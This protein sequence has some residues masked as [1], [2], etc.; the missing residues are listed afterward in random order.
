[1]M[2]FLDETVLITGAKGG[3]GKA[4][5]IK[6][7]QEGANLVLTDIDKEALDEF[8]R[9]EGFDSQRCICVACDVT[10]YKEV[11][12]SVALGVQTFGSIDHLVNCA[13]IDGRMAYIADM[14]EE[15]FDIMMNVNVKGT[16]FFMKYALQDMLKHHKGTIVNIASVAG[17]SASRRKPF[18][19]ASKHAVNGLSKSA[20]LEY[21]D[22]GIRVN[23]VCPGSV[24]TPMIRSMEERA[25]PGEPD[26]AR[27]DFTKGIPMKRYAKPEEIADLIV[28]LSGD[29]S[30]YITGNC[31]TI[32]GGIAAK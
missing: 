11:A 32:D 31:Y 23:A 3:M 26:K 19:C 27:E 21:V 10:K 16:F 15:D 22:C 6:F 2:M 4:S 29:K 28:F 7:Y 18:Y 8:V 14:E 30:T 17:V 5:A 9:Q 1:M 24:D 12:K 13:G 20:A 25:F